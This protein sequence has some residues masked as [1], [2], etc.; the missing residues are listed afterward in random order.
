MNLDR[1]IIIVAVLLLAV[2]APAIVW[3][4]QGSAMESGF[5][6]A[7][8]A[9]EVNLPIDLREKQW[10]SKELSGAVVIK[11]P[12]SSGRE[13]ALGR[14]LNDRG[15]IVISPI[16]F[17]FQGTVTDDDTGIIHVFG[18]PRNGSPKWR[19]VSIHVSS[20]N[21]HIQRRV[22]QLEEMK[23]RKAAPKPGPPDDREG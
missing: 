14:E 18:Y 4:L 11:L 10:T 15:R 8:R 19:W 17:Q 16:Q 23:A 3:S 7:L 21:E 22:Q 5:V 20:I 2:V 1:R 13:Q 6:D 12:E 9:G